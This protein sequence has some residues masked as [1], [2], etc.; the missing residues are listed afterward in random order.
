MQKS[1][2]HLFHLKLII[3]SP[4]KDAAQEHERLG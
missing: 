4:N 2:L 1:F 3:I